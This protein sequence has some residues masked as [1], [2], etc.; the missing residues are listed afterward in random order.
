MPIIFIKC[1]VYSNYYGIVLCDGKSKKIISSHNNKRNFN[2]HKLKEYIHKSIV[3]VF[4]KFD[5]QIVEA[6]TRGYVQNEEIYELYQILQNKVY[7]NKY[8]YVVMDLKRVFS[9]YKN[10]ITL[11]WIQFFL[12]DKI[13]QLE[14]EDTTITV[15]DSFKGFME[16]EYLPSQVNTMLKLF[17]RHKGFLLARIQEYRDNHFLLNS[18]PSTI[19]SEIAIKKV[20]QAMQITRDELKDRRPIYDAIDCK[21]ILLPII[22]IKDPIFKNIIAYYSTKTLLPNNAGHYQ[23]DEDGIELTYKGLPLKYGFGG[24]HGCVKGGIYQSD[25]DWKIF[26]IDFKSMYPVFTLNNQVHM[27]HI[28]W[29]IYQSVLSSAL[30][31]KDQLVRD[32]IEYDFA[33]LEANAFYGHSN[34]IHS[35]FRDP[36][37]M[38]KVTINC[39]LLTTMLYEQINQY[40]SV[41]PIF[42]NT[43]GLMLMIHVKSIPNLKKIIQYWIKVY[44]MKIVVD[45][46]ERLIMEHMNS[47][48]A[49]GKKITKRGTFMQYE[50]YL[51]SGKYDRSPSNLIISDALY[52]YFKN[53]TNPKLTILRENNMFAFVQ[54]NR[55]QTGNFVEVR[56]ERYKG[57]LTERLYLWNQSE[58]Y[59]YK[60]KQGGSIH[61]INGKRTKIIDKKGGDRVFSSSDNIDDV[62]KKMYLIE[63]VEKI[64]K[65]IT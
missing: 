35:P 1:I 48:L 11:N 51:Q 16:G 41:N 17:M 65:L 33:K 5:A 52:E 20:C 58:I 21:E 44:Q 54:T 12:R 10:N 22:K 39:Q 49:L 56:R 3:I 61:V 38:L 2:E 43:D 9:L 64:K 14:D 30:V 28:P 4:D 29:D 34:Y 32:T 24:I 26:H 6:I 37:Y 25:I 62:N 15:K 57:N 59:S 8:S 7:Y 13:I 31:R 47:Y 50:D 45:H 40:C 36:A 18:S 42:M 55:D 63:T 19:T 27:K 46:Y 60:S 53:G 23:I